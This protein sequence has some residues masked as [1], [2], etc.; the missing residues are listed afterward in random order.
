MFR[1]VLI[2]G[3]YNKACL[4]PSDLK[5]NENSNYNFSSIQLLLIDYCFLKKGKRTRTVILSNF[6]SHHKNKDAF[7]LSFCKTKIRKITEYFIGHNH[8]LLNSSSKKN[9]GQQYDRGFTI[10][11]STILRPS[12]TIHQLL[13]ICTNLMVLSIEMTSSW[14]SQLLL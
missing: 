8:F 7:H 4:M 11:T 10:L 12:S 14:L 1:C 13:W 2:S 6:S 3:L 5:R 9:P